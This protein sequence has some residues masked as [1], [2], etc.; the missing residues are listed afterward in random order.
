MKKE[1]IKKILLIG[2]GNMGTI[3]GKNIL[4]N[5]KIEN[6]NFFVIDRNK[7]KTDF[8]FKKGCNVS[9]NIFEEKFYQDIDLI[10]LAIKP[11]SF[12]EFSKMK[13]K[14]KN[15]TRVLSIM[16][17]IKTEIIEEKL[18]VE[19]V[20]RI[21]PNIPIEISKGVI[22][23]YFSKSFN[24]FEKENI[25]KLIDK[26]GVLIKCDNEDQINSITAISG[27]GPAYFYNIL[28]ILQEQAISFG[29]S[30]SV[31]KKIVL[32]TMIGSGLFAE[33]K[34]ESFKELKE[35]VTSKKGTTEKAL[36]DFK[37]NKLS[38]ILKNGIIKAKER[39]VEIEND[40]LF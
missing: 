10:I 6:K 26:F 32:Q 36:E 8:F 38:Q 37:K 4:K 29:F 40:N 2:S 3:I 39:A 5:K 13:K 15:K 35:K 18:G 20:I 11:Q 28:E 21:M 16:A 9:N 17:G 25:L 23:Y 34:D 19:K 30:E 12:L 7:D 31:S 14:I 27:S 22:G 33:K 1:N 24:D